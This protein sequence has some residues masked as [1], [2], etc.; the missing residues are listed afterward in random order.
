MY[1]IAVLISGGGTN[2]QSIIDKVKAGYL[3]CK[4]EIVISDNEK[5]YGIERA[6]E[7]DIYAVA[8][9][10]K[11]YGDKL[12]DEILKISQERNV[13]LIV[14]AGFLS[15]IKGDLLKKFKNRIIN[16]HPS[17]IPSFCGK[18]MY[19][20]NVHEAAIEYGVKISGC[21]V[22]FVDE[23]TDTGPIIIQKSVPV[24]AEDTAEELQKRVLEKEHE[25][26]PEAI[27]LIETGKVKVHERKVIIENN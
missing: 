12:S 1:K 7:N 14:T 25:A 17:L 24:F 27:K 6:K 11:Q 15:I 21:T 19:G 5:A 4:I 20:L 13:D 8:L 22:H 10:K 26:L 16:I 9:S 23:G 18:G 3:D 2:L